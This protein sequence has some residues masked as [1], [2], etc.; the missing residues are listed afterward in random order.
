MDN[1]QIEAALPEMLVHLA[2]L[3]AHM[4]REL[5]GDLD[6]RLDGWRERF[7]EFFSTRQRQ[8]VAQPFVALRGTDVIGM[9]MASVIDDY[10]TFALEQRRGYIN[11]VYV[12]PA[13]RGNGIGRKLT[14]AAIAWLRER[15]CV[16]VRL[17][18]SAKAQP[19]YRS[20]GFAPS[21]ELK[22]DL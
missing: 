22:L 12:I 1:V 6:A 8:G 5:E 19:L 2:E 13:E 18:P 16:A 20:M 9:A 4:E 21:G 10:R 11:T 15:G 14:E 3:R 17:N 7:V